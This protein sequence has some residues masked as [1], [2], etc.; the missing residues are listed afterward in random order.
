MTG[1]EIQIKDYYQTILDNNF[2]DTSVN[3]KYAMEYFLSNVL[4]KGDYSRVCYSKEDIA[5]RRRV[6]TQGN[7]SIKSGSLDYMSL[8]LPFAA[9]SQTGSL[10]EDDRPY[11]NNTYAAVVGHIDPM[12]GVNVKHIPTKIKY[13]ATAFFS[14]LDSRDIASQLLFQEMQPKGPFY[15]IAQQEFAGQPIDIPVNVTLE[16]FDSNP[17]YNEK[18]FL[19]DSKIFPIKMD[20]TIRT[21]LLIIENIDNAVSLPIRFSHL[22]AYNNED[23]VYTDKCTL[24]WA[25]NKWPCEHYAIKDEE[26][27]DIDIKTGKPDTRNAHEKSLSESLNETYVGSGETEISGNESAKEAFIAEGKMIKE[28][29]GETIAEAIQGYMTESRD[30]VLEEFSQNDEKTTENS[31]TVSWKIRESDEQYFSAI[32]IYVPGILNIKLKDIDINEYEITGL[33]PGS[34]YD[35][36]LIVFAKNST[37]LTY[38]LQLHTKGEKVVTKKL[39]DLLVGKSFTMDPNF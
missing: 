30:C 11:A 34:D 21:Y 6:E 17:E 13:S 18:K 35:C 15:F 14:S 9:Y 36:T 10:E 26:T 1:Q 28:E 16:G 3:C 37:K 39:S 38:K 20:F 8:H 23:I 5:F 31:A 27:Q 25:H 19:E 12:T 7:G 33:Y 4:F 22:Y 32:K 2:I 29:I 24:I